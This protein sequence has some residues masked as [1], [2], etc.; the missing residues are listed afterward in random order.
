MSNKQR[1]VSILLPAEVVERAERIVAKKK[2]RPDG[3]KLTVTSQ[4][5]EWVIDG[6]R[7]LKTEPYKGEGIKG[8]LVVS[9]GQ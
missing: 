8:R 9:N 2:T 3:L 4:L 5:R 1:Q 7:L 6:S